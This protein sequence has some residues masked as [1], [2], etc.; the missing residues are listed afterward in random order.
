[1]G[2]KRVL[3]GS[4]DGTARI[5][6]VKSRE[7]MLKIKTGHKHVWA[8]IYSPNNTKIATGGYKENAVKIWDAKTGELIVTLGHN[9]PLLSLTWTSDG[10]KLISGS[11]PIRIFDTA[12][13]REIATLDGHKDW[14]HAITL[15]QNN[16]LLV[17]ASSDETVCLWNLDTNLPVGPLLKHKHE[18]QCVALSTDGI[19]VTGGRDNNAYVWD[20]HA[21][22]KKAGLEDLLFIPYVSPS[23]ACSSNYTNFPL[24][25]PSSKVVKGCMC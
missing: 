18:L 22:L 16:R 24:A 14:V 10:K 12:T 20:I 2:G 6:D 15:S 7:T 8:V 9:Y 19:L 1:M 4:L 21:I 13:W 17:S 25:G 11:Y 5:W 3:S 23:A